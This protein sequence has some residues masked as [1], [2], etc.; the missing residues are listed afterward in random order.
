MDNGSCTGNWFISGKK[1]QRECKFFKV[2][3]P[4]EVAYSTDRNWRWSNKKGRVVVVFSSKLFL[5]SIIVVLKSHKLSE[6]SGALNFLS[7]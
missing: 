3:G 4:G 6:F 1:K 2:V 5:I 7:P